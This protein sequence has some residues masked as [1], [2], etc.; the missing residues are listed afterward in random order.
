MPAAVTGCGGPAPRLLRPRRRHYGAPSGECAERWCSR[1][2]DSSVAGVAPAPGVALASAACIFEREPRVSSRRPRVARAAA[3][4]CPP[5]LSPPVLCRAAFILVPRSP[6]L[7]SGPA[8]AAPCLFVSAALFSVFLSAVWAGVSVLLLLLLLLRL[9]R[10]P[11]LSFSRLAFP[12]LVTRRTLD[13]VVFVNKVKLVNM[14]VCPE[15]EAGV[16]K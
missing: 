8:P 9:R 16:L 4:R 3:P 14:S 11:E 12:E 2:A 6:R 1:S 5:P 15:V 7:C 13:G 10:G